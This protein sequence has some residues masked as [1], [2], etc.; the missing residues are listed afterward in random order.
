MRIVRRSFNK[1]EK[2]HRLDMKHMNEVIAQLRSKL[3]HDFSV[4]TPA[5]G[6]SPRGTYAIQDDKVA[7]IRYLDENVK[8]CKNAFNI[9]CT[10]LTLLRQLFRLLHCPECRR[11]FSVPKVT[12]QGVTVCATCLPKHVELRGEPRASNNLVVDALLTE[13]RKSLP[14]NIAQLLRDIQILQQD[15]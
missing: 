13:F 7:K 6:T 12:T 14:P 9:F 5:Y 2:K 11:P 15:V 3:V 10:S 8:R 1:A 4:K